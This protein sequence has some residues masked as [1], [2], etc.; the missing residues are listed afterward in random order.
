MTPDQTAARIMP[1]VKAISQLPSLSYFLI[2]LTKMSSR[3]KRQGYVNVG[4]QHYVVLADQL[5][6]AEAVELEGVLQRAC[7]S[8]PETEPRYHPEKNRS[9]RKSVGGIGAAKEA[10]SVYLAWYSE[11]EE[12]VHV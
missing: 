12:Q 1:T 3:A 10:Y 7:F 11:A 9:H 4:M 5:T 6:Q 2:G 8:C